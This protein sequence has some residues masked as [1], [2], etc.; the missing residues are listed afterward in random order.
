MWFDLQRVLTPITASKLIQNQKGW[1]NDSI[2]YL[3]SD[4]KD[5]QPYA[6]RKTS[7]TDCPFV[8]VDGKGS[9]RRY[10]YPAD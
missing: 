2:H 6:V 5:L 1:I 8:R 3:M 4:V 9:P 7:D 10:F